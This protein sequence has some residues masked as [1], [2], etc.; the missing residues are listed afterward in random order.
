MKKLL[1]TTALL[2]GCLARSF[3]ANPEPVRFI[4]D[5]DIGND[6]D[7]V[8]ALGMI[9]NL[10]E[11]GIC[12]LLAVTITKDSPKAAAFTD[13]MNTFYGHPN[14]PIGVVKNG[15][16]NGDGK[17]LPLAD[18][19]DNGKLRFPH[20]LKSG[21]DAPE[22]TALL[23]Q[24]LSKEADHSVVIAQVGFFT[25][26]ERLLASGPDQYSPLSGRDLIKQKVKLLSI[27]AG[28]FQTIRDNNHYLEYN[29]I[30]DIPAAQKLAKEW[31]TPIVWSGYEIG[32]SVPYPAVSIERDF[33]YVPH[34][35]VAEAYVLY[36]PPPHERPTWDLTAVLYGLMS[37]RG[38]FTLSTPGEVTVEKDG[39]TRFK[40]KKDGRD[41]FLILNDL[42]I[43]RLKEALVQLSSEPPK[44]LGIR[45]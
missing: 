39:F 14:V 8:M 28:S 23:R 43:A 37:D 3:S 31:P 40:P 18:K 34:H 45:K 24:T 42:Q 32:I 2:L 38:Y 26:L 11:R 33:N 27:M 13:A 44:S 19:M 4:F 20:D 6:V 22:A 5:T 7:D 16:K 35:P 12:K 25:N 1:L 21:D 36:N 41:R 17:F 15:V 9:H 10:E 29:V 30:K